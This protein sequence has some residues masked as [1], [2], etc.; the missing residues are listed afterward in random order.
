MVQGRDAARREIAMVRYVF[1]RVVCFALL[2]I[3]F[4]LMSLAA[5]AEGDKDAKPENKDN[6]KGGGA[7]IIPG[8]QAGQLTSRELMDLLQMALDTKDLQNP[9]T[10]KDVLTVVYSQYQ[11]RGKELP[12]LIDTN[13][14]KEDNA[15]APS[16]YEA[17]V[18]FPEFPR[19]MTGAMVLKIAMSQIP[20]NNAALILRDGAVLITTQTQASLGRLLQ[21]KML[22]R[23]DNRPLSEVLQSLADKTGISYAIDPRVKDK[24]ETRV[25]AYFGNDM[26]LGG[27]LRI[28]VDMAGLKMVD[29][30]SGLYVT[31]PANA[32][33]L[34]KE[35]R[36]SKNTPG[37]SPAP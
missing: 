3:G 1:A 27:A 30:Q 14:F 7:K 10:F 19:K 9:L 20:T 2:G 23:F 36:D 16:P 12:M 37:N 22:S 29:M 26:T 32:Q 18:R 31:S 11:D 24:A 21:E 15:D 33:I 28:L 6:Q 13:A 34:E 8:G 35:L 4:G 25:T 5:R 17:Q